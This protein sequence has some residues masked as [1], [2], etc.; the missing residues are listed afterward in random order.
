RTIS[1]DAVRV[2]VDGKLAIDD[3]AP[4]ESVVDHAPLAG[5]R[6]RLRVEY[7]QVD[8]WVE[9]RLDFVRGTESSTGTAGP[10]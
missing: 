4:H 6:H 9:L 10:H 2:W 3:W 7:Y 8:G 5:G 1:D